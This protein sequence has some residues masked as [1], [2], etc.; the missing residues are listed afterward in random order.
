MDGVPYPQPLTGQEPQYVP[1]GALL[2]RPIGHPPGRCHLGP[3][4][5][6]PG[7]NPPYCLRSGGADTDTGGPIRTPDLALVPPSGSFPTGGPM[8]AL[9]VRV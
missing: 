6:G 9:P 8:H 2:V 7:R 1:W 5:N 4:A 3:L